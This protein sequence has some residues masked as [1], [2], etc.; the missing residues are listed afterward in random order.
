VLRSVAKNSLPS[1]LMTMVV[2]ASAEAMLTS[3]RTEVFALIA[4]TSL[5][6]GTRFPD[7]VDALDQS[8]LAMLTIV[9]LAPKF[10]KVSYGVEYGFVPFSVMLA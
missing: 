10:G 9:G 4:T 3:N 1:S 8:P 6:A 5:A 2:T 7:H